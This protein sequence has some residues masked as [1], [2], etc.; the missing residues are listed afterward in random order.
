MNL[1]P[2]FMNLAPRVYQSWAEGSRILGGE[3]EKKRERE[4]ERDGEREREREREIS[5]RD[6][7]YS[8]PAGQCNRLG[9]ALEIVALSMGI[10]DKKHSGPKAFSRNP[11]HGAVPK[12]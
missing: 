5:C 12:P 11:E 4:R 10:D 8:R 6:T 2:G 1:G 9:H 3:R 7:S